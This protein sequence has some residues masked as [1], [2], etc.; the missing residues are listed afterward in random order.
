MVFVVLGLAVEL[1]M[2]AAP[3]RVTRLS[4]QPLHGRRS[5]RSRRVRGRQRRKRVVWRES[6]GARARRSY[7]VNRRRGDDG[8]RRSDGRRT[9]R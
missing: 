6:L 3:A 2:V 4:L 9:S 8:G 7:G 1:S 5:E